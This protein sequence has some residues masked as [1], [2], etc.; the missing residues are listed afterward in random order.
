MAASRSGKFWIGAFSTLTALIVGW[1]W[2]SGSPPQ[3][4]YDPDAFAAVDALFTAI[5][6]RNTSTLSQCEQRL[7]TLAQNGRIPEPAA[8]RL[9]EI[10]AIA[11]AGDWMHSGQSL[12]SF[13]QG[14][15]RDAK[16]AA[17]KNS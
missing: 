16:S 11:R 7:A 3:M 9:S 12:Y 14:Q 4:D 1:I 8:S 17:G 2:W 13:I 15:R 10:V 5:N 6:A